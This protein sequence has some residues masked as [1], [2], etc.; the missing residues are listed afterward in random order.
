MSV[1]VLVNVHLLHAYDCR[2]MPSMPHLSDYSLSNCLRYLQCPAWW[3]TLRPM[4]LCRLYSEFLPS[5]T[6]GVTLSSTRGHGGGFLCHQANVLQ[7]ILRRLGSPP[8]IDQRVVRLSH[9]GNS[10]KSRAAILTCLTP[11]TI[12]T[13]VPH[14][15]LHLP[16]H[17]LQIVSTEPGGQ[18]DNANSA[19]TSRRLCR[20]PPC[21]TELDDRLL[22]LCS[23]AACN[24][25]PSCLTIF[26]TDR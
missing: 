17:P 14:S 11:V 21:H 18:S 16:H 8:R 6:S 12:G 5:S 2:R 9:V 24:G 7:Y 23:K 4:I 3:H 10:D 13:A 1:V 22:K 26:T 19:H 25:E 15:Q 20:S